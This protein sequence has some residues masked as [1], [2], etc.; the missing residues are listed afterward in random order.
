[1]EFRRVRGADPRP[2]AG[3]EGRRVVLLWACHIRAV[4]AQH[5][6][7]GVGRRRVHTPSGRSEI[8]KA[9]AGPRPPQR[10]QALGLQGLLEPGALPALSAGRR[11]SVSGGGEG[12]GHAGGVEGGRGV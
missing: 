2:R 4:G 11:V 9:A 10:A 1:M 12:G 3:V 8:Q 6:W 5:V 7:V